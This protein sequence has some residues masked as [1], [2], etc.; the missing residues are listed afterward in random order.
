MNKLVFKQLS[1]RGF[2]IGCHVKH[3][4][5]R[6]YALEGMAVHTE[7]CEY[8]VI[9]RSLEDDKLYARP[10]GMF[11]S[12]VDR[13]KYPDVKQEYRFEVEDLYDE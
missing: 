6:L 10:L 9:Y 5:G 8:L 1:E 7:M 11:L 3:F 4:K 2:Y 13:E 12:K